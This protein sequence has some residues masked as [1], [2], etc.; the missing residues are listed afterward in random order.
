MPVS[1][2]VPLVIMPS[3]AA[4]YAT[5]RS[6]GLAR[7]A[8]YHLL[9]SCVPL[10]LTKLLSKVS[11]QFTLAYGPATHGIDTAI[12]L[13]RRNV[14]PGQSR[15]KSASWMSIFSDFPV[16]RNSINAEGNH[17]RRLI[18]FVSSNSRALS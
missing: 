5:K 4:L 16:L 11:E 13:I 1:A 9:D 15:S 2:C 7:S 17:S 10:T 8:G 12:D 3:F 18:C 6:S 14:C